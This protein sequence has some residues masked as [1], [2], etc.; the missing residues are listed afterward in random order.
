MELTLDCAGL[1]V[2]I[3]G[4]TTAAR[5]T[6][7]RY[8]AGGATVRRIATPAQFHPRLLDAVSLAV[9]VEDPVTAHDDGAPLGEQNWEPLRAAC[10]ERRILTASEEPAATGGRVTLIGGGPGVEDLLTVRAKQAL[11]EAD[12]VLYDRLG[13]YRTLPQLAPGAEL[14]D[15]GKTPGHHPVSQAEIEKLMVAKAREGKQVVRLKGGDPFVFGRGG[16]EVNTCLAEG[17]PVT[18]VP[19]ISSSIAVPAAAGIPVTYRGV[20]HA[21]TVISGHQPLTSAE[22]EALAKLGGTI[23]VLMGIG[24]LPQLTSGLRKAGLASSVPVAIVEKGY[25]PEQRTTVTTLGEAVTAAGLARCTSPAV[26]V[27]GE[28][29]RQHRDFSATL[30][31]VLAQPLGAS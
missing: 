27:I 14:I 31:R 21:F 26:V 2:L 29:V 1:T 22:F 28:V 12:V 9:V 4:T 24:T 18:T 11:R 17:I 7:R 13:P 5:H 30:E 10:R 20:A 6:V 19:G 25:S 8:T 3:A 16:E 15:V 23:V